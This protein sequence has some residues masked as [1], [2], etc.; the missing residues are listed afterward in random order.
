LFWAETSKKEEIT[1]NNK[2]N[3][4]KKKNSG[5]DFFSGLFIFHKG[6]VYNQLSSFFL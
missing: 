6:K 4:N 2:D 3:P 1:K 5:S